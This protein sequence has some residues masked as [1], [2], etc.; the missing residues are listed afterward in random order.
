MN[1]D[2][3]FMSTVKHL[4]WFFV[5]S[6]S[7]IV[8]SYQLAVVCCSELSSNL[9]SK[10]PDLLYSCDGKEMSEVTHKVDISSRLPLL[11]EY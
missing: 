4:L 11:H 8:C 3:L 1:E 9:S 2:D 7:G 6:Q 5:L 10:S